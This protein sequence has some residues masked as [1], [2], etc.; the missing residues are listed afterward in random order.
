MLRRVDSRFVLV[1]TVR[2]VINLGRR[3]LGVVARNGT[4]LFGFHGFHARAGFAFFHFGRY[5]AR[6]RACVDGK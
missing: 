2:L 4:H 3:T 6:G 1:V 5:Y